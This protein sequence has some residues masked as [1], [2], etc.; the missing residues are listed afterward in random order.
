MRQNT[1]DT[2]VAVKVG[3]DETPFQSKLNALSQSQSWYNWAG[4]KSASHFREGA[5]EYFALRNRATVFDIS[6][7][8][9]YR[10]IGPDAVNVLNRMA[11]RDVSKIRPGRVGYTLWCDEDGMVIDDGTI[12]RFGEDDLVLMCQERM[13]SWLL[14]IAWGFDARVED[15]QQDL[16]GLAL[17]GPCS[18]S[19]L[20]DVGWESLADM[21]PFDL[22]EIEPGVWISRTGYTGDLGY[23]FTTTPDKAGQLWDR[24][25]DAGERWGLTPMGTDA[26]D[27][28]RI[29]AGY[30]APGV[31]FFPVHAVSRLHRGRTPF[32][33]GFG[34]MVNFAKGHFNGRRALLEHARKGPRHSLV[35]LDIEG[36]VPATDAYVYAGNRFVGMVRSAVWSPTF[37]R[38][39]ALADLKAPWGLS[40]TKGLWVEVYVDHEG[41]WQKRKA[42][43]TVVKGPFMDMPRA[44]ATPPGTV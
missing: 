20:K 3:M 15:V 26:L 44:R 34:K 4:F 13:M 23:E 38:N 27:I 37:K 33:L 16:C 24:I 31:D 9:K 35:R 2:L 7:M 32:E 10:V 17:Q 41:I 28:A 42:R 18:Y 22:R 30:M 29:E 36:D 5:E 19:V 14:D 12:F 43:A 6:P 8:C 40:R 25:W 39:L 21:K 1:K 11:I